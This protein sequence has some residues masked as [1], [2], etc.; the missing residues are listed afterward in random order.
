MSNAGL[1]DC[2]GGCTMARKSGDPY[3]QDVP[4]QGHDYLANRNCEEERG[5]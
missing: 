4:E 2:G 1:A 3:K 5:R